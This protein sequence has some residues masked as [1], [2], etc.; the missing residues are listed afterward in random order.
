MAR[1]YFGLHQRGVAHGLFLSSGILGGGARAQDRLIA[2]AEHLR[3]K[4]HYRGYLHL[5]LMPGAEYDQVLRAMQLADRVLVNLEARPTRSGW[6]RWPR[7]RPSWSESCSNCC[8][9]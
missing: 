2:M 8:A 5:K 6:R 7:K 4:L 1:L 3:Y 9:G